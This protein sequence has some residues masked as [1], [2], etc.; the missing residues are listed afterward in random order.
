MKGM[1]RLEGGD[2]KRR[3]STSVARI[4]VPKVYTHVSMYRASFTVHLKLSHVMPS[5]ILY[6]LKDSVNTILP[7]QVLIHLW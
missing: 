2:H 1:E 5:N 4:D 7:Q 3:T 6:D